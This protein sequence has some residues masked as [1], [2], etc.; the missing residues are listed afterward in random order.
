[1]TS[2]EREVEL[3]DKIFIKDELIKE[4]QEK[5]QMEEMVKKS[6]IYLNQDLKERIEKLELHNDTLIKINE[7][8]SNIISK[9]RLQLKNILFKI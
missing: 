8:Y 3:L 6:E 2:K 1:M 9:L 5:L 4:L 7:N